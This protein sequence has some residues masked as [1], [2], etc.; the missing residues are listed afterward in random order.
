MMP[1]VPGAAR[2]VGPACI[3]LGVLLGCSM[4]DAD[5]VS[6]EWMH[7]TMFGEP[8]RSGPGGVSVEA[9]GSAVIRIF[10]EGK[11]EDACAADPTKGFR[12]EILMAQFQTGR[13]E[14][15]TNEGWTVEAWQGREGMRDP[16]SIIEIDLAQEQVGGSVTGCARFGS[17]QSG[18]LVEG[19][20]EAT[21]CSIG[22]P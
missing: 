17:A 19:R 3:A 21:V 10:E 9:D 2:K 8:F 16:Y 6:D 4:D 7:G 5:E 13:Y 22:S 1:R 15:A 11:V 14:A 20:F 12:I 18:D